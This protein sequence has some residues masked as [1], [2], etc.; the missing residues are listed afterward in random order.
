MNNPNKLGL[1][2][3]ASL[4]IQNHPFTNFFAF[5][6]SYLDK[7]IAF[8][9]SEYTGSLNSSEN[10]RELLQ[11]IQEIEVKIAEVKSKIKK[12]SNFRD[13]VK[14]NIELKNLSDE[15]EKLKGSL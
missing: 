9:A 5:Y 14:M 1:D 13:K 3:I 6:N 8:N 11:D 4:E 10:T 7:I 2:F 12:E 15:L